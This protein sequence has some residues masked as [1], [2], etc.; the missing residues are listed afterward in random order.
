MRN[1]TKNKHVEHKVSM[2]KE[3][4]PGKRY[5]GDSGECPTTE[6]HRTGSTNMT[7]NTAT[8]KA[9]PAPT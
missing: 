3:A 4:K 7:Q 2:P 8:S 9:C 6:W 5:L 1:K